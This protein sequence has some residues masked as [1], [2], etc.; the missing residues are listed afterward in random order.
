MVALV[1]QVVEHILVLAQTELE[2]HPPQV[3][4]LQL[5]TQMLVAIHYLTPMN[6]E[7][8]L[9]EVVGQDWLVPH[10]L[11]NKMVVMVVMDRQLSRLG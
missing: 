3:R 1:V 7:E 11:L 8:E 2:E 6:L 9:V 4:G 10:L 5:D